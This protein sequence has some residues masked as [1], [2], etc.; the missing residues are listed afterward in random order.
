MKIANEVIS[1]FKHESICP[2]GRALNATTF[3]H[4]TPQTIIGKGYCVSRLQMSFL[5]DSS[6]SPYVLM[7]ERWMLPYSYIRRQ[8]LLFVRNIEYED[9]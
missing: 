2:D 8:R 4:S 6:T 7:L 1:W 3:V 5:D 9:C